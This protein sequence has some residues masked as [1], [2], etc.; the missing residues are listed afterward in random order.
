MTTDYEKLATWMG[1][2]VWPHTWNPSV[3]ISDARMLVERAWEKAIAAK[4]RTAEP[5]IIPLDELDVKLIESIAH[6]DPAYHPVPKFKTLKAISERP[7]EEQLVYQ[8]SCILAASVS[9]KSNMVA[10][11]IANAVL[12]VLE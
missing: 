4:N 12:E 8:L 9:W 3:N 2:E 5:L 1:W 10:A 7:K 11:A 6:Y